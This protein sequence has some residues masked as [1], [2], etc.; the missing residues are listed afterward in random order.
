MTLGEL[1]ASMT[2]SSA[3]VGAARKAFADAPKVLSPEKMNQLVKDVE[4]SISDFNAAVK[5]RA[6]ELNA[7]GSMAIGAATGAVH[8]QFGNTASSG[9]NMAGSALMRAGGIG[10]PIGKVLVG[11]GAVAGAAEQLTKAF[12]DRAKQLSKFSPSIAVAEA[13]SNVKLMMADMREAQ[14]LGPDMGRLITASTDVQIQIRE[15]ILPLKRAL[16]NG[17]A[18]LLEMVSKLLPDGEQEDWTDKIAIAITWLLEKFDVDVAAIRQNLEQM[19]KERKAE[20]LRR[21]AAES[22]RLNNRLMENAF[23]DLLP[24]LPDA[25]ANARDR[26]WDMGPGLPAFH[27]L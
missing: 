6:S 11:F 4:K 19:A 23:K 8:N 15:A 16:V 5:K 1:I 24:M 21:A 27:G 14:A 13:M 9:L 22:E 2:T 18:S 25:V 20:A 17:L 3:G 10:G 12:L 26:G 7:F